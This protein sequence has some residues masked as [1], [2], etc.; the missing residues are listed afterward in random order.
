MEFEATPFTRKLEELTTEELCAYAK[1]K[2]Q[3]EY[4]A[5]LAQEQQE[6]VRR[7]DEK[8]RK[9]LVGEKTDE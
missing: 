4:H 7:L 6:I 3:R 2:K 5:K 8:M 1:Y 9:V